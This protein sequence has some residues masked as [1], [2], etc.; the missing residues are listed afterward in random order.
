MRTIRRSWLLGLVAVALAG[1]VAY[2]PVAAPGPSTFDRAWD[3]A[4]GAAADSGV[5]VT[6]ADRNSGRIRGTK[7]GAEATIDVLPQADGTVRVEIIAPTSVQSEPTL[8][9]QL[10]EA[11]QR[12][13][14]R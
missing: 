10:S 12:R 6:A 4:L 7:A 1:C 5:V 13:L 9:K 3:A 11:Y 14:G 8:S 2:Y